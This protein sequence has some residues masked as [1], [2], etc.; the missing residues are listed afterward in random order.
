MLRNSPLRQSGRSICRGLSWGCY[1]CLG[2]VTTDFALDIPLLSILDQEPLSLKA[3]LGPDNCHQVASVTN[4]KGSLDIRDEETRR[5][6]QT[7]KGQLL[8]VPS[9]R[10]PL[11][12][13]NRAE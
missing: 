3:P 5:Q 10:I 4:K 12:A 2:V 7:T 1:P 11:L 8:L 9:V 6:A 13:A